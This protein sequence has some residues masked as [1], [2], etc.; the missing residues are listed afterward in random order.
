MRH[1]R[2]RPHSEGSRVGCLEGPLRPMNMG[3]V[4]PEGMR[5]LRKKV[6]SNYLIVMKVSLK[7]TIQFLIKVY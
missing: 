1:W 7:S 2:D 6:K 3:E 4:V 5:K